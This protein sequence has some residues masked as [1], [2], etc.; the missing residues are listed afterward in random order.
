MKNKQV[1]SIRGIIM[2][3]IMFYHYTYRFTELYN[4]NTINFFSLDNWGTIGVNTFFIISGYYMLSKDTLQYNAKEFFIKKFFRLYPAYVLCL[5]IT[6]I[7]MLIFGLENRT[8]TFIDYIINLF[9]VNG[10]IGIPY[11]DGGHWY[12][13]YLILF[14]VI[15]SLAIYFKMEKRKFIICW[16]IC[17][18]TLL[19]SSHFFSVLSHIYKVTGGQ[20]AIF[21]IMG[22]ILRE[23][24]DRNKNKKINILI[25]SLA[26]IENLILNNIIATIGIIIFILCFVLVLKKEINILKNQLL[27]ALGTISYIVYLL[28]Q[29]IGYQ[30]LL[31][32]NNIYKQY[33][34][35]FTICP[36]IIIIAMSI[37]IYQ[38]YERAI[39]RK[40]Q[41]QKSHT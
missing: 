34:L 23:L 7:S 27:T 2:V 5:T 19:I 12:L 20:Y 26:F 31:C 10:F 40:L 39:Q 21:I 36:I 17:N 18:T 33:N 24:I 14:Y 6:F 32:L 38:Y 28:H 13:T 29:N 41:S 1:E 16:I 11:V 8:V 4:I 22:I 25:L 15:V 3:M 37:I 9:M 30:I 35:L